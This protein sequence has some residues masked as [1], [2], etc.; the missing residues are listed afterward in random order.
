MV[1]YLS[2]NMAIMFQDDQWSYSTFFVWFESMKRKKQAFCFLIVCLFVCLL[3]LFQRNCFCCFVSPFPSC[4]PCFRSPNIFQRC[5]R[6]TWCGGLVEA[7]RK[8]DSNFG[9]GCIDC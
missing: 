3:S 8:L 2:G 5:P 1:S 4:F 6:W 9:D 7:Q